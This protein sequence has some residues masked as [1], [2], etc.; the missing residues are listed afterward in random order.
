MMYR[1]G[2]VLLIP[3]A[4]I[5]ENAQA[6]PIEHGRVI[7]AH[8]EATGH[9]HSFEAGPDVQL[10]MADKERF[11][12]V[13]KQSDLTHQEHATISVPPGTFQ[14]VRQREYDDTEEWRYVVD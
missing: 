7:L 10:L 3:V 4:C 14:V 5:P 8:G 2:D 6:V 13:S 9:H 11:L 1:Q 12:Q